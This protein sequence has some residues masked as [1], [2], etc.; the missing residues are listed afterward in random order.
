[1]ATARRTVYYFRLTPDSLPTLADKIQS[2]SQVPID[3]RAHSHM[4]QQVLFEAEEVGGMLRGFVTILRQ[5]GL[6]A[7]GRLN[8]HEAR[9]LDLADDEGLSETSHFVLDNGGLLGFEYNHYGPRASLLVDAVD[10]VYGDIF[11]DDAPSSEYDVLLGQD[12]FDIIQSARGIKVVEMAVARSNLRTSDLSNESLNQAFVSS[13]QLG[14]TGRVTLVLTG[15]QQN[16][17]I[18]M[19]SGEFFDTLLPQGRQSLGPF[20]KFKAKIVNE[21]GATE[22]IDLLNDRVKTRVIANTEGRGRSIRRGSVLDQMA[23]DLARIRR[24][25]VG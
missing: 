2:L 8:T 21:S 24:D 19:R 4:G 25:H 6:P 22:T 10:K 17:G 1:M 20:E 7:V 11:D 16:R 9:A 23:I 3:Q 13:E 12:G 14:Q 18:F 5:S 15:D